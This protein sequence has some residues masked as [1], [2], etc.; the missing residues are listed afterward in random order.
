MDNPTE[1][2]QRLDNGKL[3][4]VVKNYRQYGYE[5]DIRSAAIEILESRGID[6][7]ILNIRGDLENRSYDDAAYHYEA[8]EKFSLAAFVL[9]SIALIVKILALFLA[10]STESLQIVV[11]IIFWIVVIGYII[12]LIQSFIS[13]TKYYKLIG[14]KERQLSPQLYFIVGMLLYIVM[15]FFFRKQVKEDINLIR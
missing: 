13:Q 1:K 15:F 5:D 10:G 14:K 3:I 12:S 4:D 9:Y 7:A 6:R 2:L 11:V 8:F